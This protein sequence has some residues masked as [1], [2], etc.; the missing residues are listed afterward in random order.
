MDDLCVDIGRDPATLRRGVNLFD[1]EARAAGGRLRYY[2][3]EEL[4]VRLV[5]SYRD[6]GYTDIG[7]YYPSESSQLDAFERIARHVIPDLRQTA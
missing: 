1:A 5:T 7:L 4:F 2:D 6:A 3:E